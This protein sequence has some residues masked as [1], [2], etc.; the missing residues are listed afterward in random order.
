MRHSGEF[1]LRLTPN[2]H[3]EIALQAAEQD[4]SLNELAA[5]RVLAH[6]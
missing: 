5:S 6:A 1:L 4:M 2:Q 3:S